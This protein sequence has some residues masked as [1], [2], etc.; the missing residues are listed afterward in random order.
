MDGGVGS[1]WKTSLSRR[2]MR[3]RR[4][5]RVPRARRL[6]WPGYVRRSRLP[7]FTW[8]MGGVVKSLAATPLAVVSPLF[9]VKHEGRDAPGLGGRVCDADQ[10]PSRA[11]WRSCSSDLPAGSP[12]SDSGHSAPRPRNQLA[13]V[14]RRT[15]STQPR[16]IVPPRGGPIPPPPGRRVVRS[17][18]LLASE[19]PACRLL[20]Q[21]C[22]S[23]LPAT[24]ATARELAQGQCRAQMGRAGQFGGRTWP[25]SPRGRRRSHR[26][27]RDPSPPP[28]DPPR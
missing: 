3:I 1:D 28:E 10:R 22:C 16:G 12:A 8:N 4:F 24:A 26:W 7:S 17:S 15:E 20:A 2:R 6:S 13:L 19:N 27:S 9:H 25:P 18:G 14:P 11:V 5:L 23:D 21:S